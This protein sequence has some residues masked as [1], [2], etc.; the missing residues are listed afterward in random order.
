MHQHN[1][2][3]KQMLS[4]IAM[5]YTEQTEL[6]LKHTGKFQSLTGSTV[7]Q[8]PVDHLVFHQVT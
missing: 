4:L 7:Q 3:M 2:V 8:A 5:D 1:L 6:V